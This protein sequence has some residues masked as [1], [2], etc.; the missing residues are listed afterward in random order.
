MGVALF[1]A[2][3]G[4]CVV[5]GIVHSIRLNDARA[6]YKAALSH[7]TLNPADNDARIAAL[8]AGRHYANLARKAA[9]QKKRAIFDEVALSNDLSARSGAP[10]SR[11]D[12]SKQCPQ[13][14]EQ[15]KGQARLC[16][17]CQYRFAEAA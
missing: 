2:F 10:S 3:V 11:S 5:I 13:C 4:V 6:A 17:F 16:R 12:D 8:E 1:V 15:V 14:A 7:L 9:G